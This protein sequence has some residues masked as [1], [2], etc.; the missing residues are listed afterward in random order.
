MTIAPTLQK[1]LAHHEVAYDLVPHQ[2]T[3]SSLHTAEAC[4]IPGDRLAKGILLRDPASCWLA[5]VP[6]SRR[7]WLPDLQE[8]LG[9]SVDLA[10]EEEISEVFRD[11]APGAIPPVG[12]CYGLDVIVDGSID[13]QPDLY[14][15]G[16]DHETL[17]HLSQSEFARLNPH[18][19]HGRFTAQ[20]TDAQG[21]A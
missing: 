18:A 9:E 14:F 12:P 20:G 2:P 15:E 4:H 13:Q 7:V 10:S 11:C 3:Q 17:V 6:A 1:Y 21:Q 8:K 19:R 5:I 16:G